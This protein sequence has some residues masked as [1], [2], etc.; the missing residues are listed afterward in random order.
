MSTLNRRSFMGQALTFS[1]VGGFAGA[2]TLLQARQLES[3][4]QHKLL[5]LYRDSSIESSAFAAQLATAGIE[6]RAL[7]EDVVRQ[8]R[9]GLEAELLTNNRL[10][11]GMGNWADFTLLKGL[12]AEVR[13]FPL[14][15]M[16]HPLK[17]QTQDWAQQHAQELLALTQLSNN[18][19]LDLALT[20]L[21]KRNE[22]EPLAPS[23]F[24]WV[25]G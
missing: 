3:L 5:V 12:A 6:T 2:S 25:L 23:L 18:A 11:L 7:T 24:S 10:L 20:A 4:Q 15:A 1:S 17:L 8:W 16:Q 21:S 22:L 13:R 19:E 14:L 9:D